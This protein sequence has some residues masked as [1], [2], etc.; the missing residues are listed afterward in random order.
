MEPSEEDPITPLD[1]EE[2][3]ALLRSAEVGRLAVSVRGEPDVFPVNYVVDGRSVVFRTAEGAKLLE[4]TINSRVA[5][6]ADGWDERFAWSVVIKGAARRVE[7]EVE[8]LR[9]DTLP[10]RPW[11][12]TLK[13]NYVRIEPGEVTGRRLLRGEEPERYPV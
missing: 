5:F 6:E 10:L 11:T 8:I 13:Y 1:E 7:R 9:A 4:L 3:W 2:C 12:A